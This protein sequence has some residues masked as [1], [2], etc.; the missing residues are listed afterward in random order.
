MTALHSLLCFVVE[1]S[2]NNKLPT[3]SI[4]FDQLLYVRAYEIV[5]SNKMEIFVRL[6]GFHQLISFLGFIGSLIEGGGL[7]NCIC[8]L[9][10]WPHDDWKSLYPSCAWSYYGRICCLIVVARGIL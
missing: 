10:R 4:T 8:S 3:P 9:N 7:R 2:K 1:Q 6:G 5:M